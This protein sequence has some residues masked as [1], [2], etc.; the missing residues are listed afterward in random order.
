M[1]TGLVGL[2]YS[3]IWEHTRRK[4]PSPPTSVERLIMMENMCRRFYYIAISG[5]EKS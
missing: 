1:E 3:K 4:R 2:D 5:K